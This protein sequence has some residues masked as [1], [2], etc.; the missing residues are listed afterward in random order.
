MD[1]LDKILA[2]QNLG[3]RKEVGAMIRKGRVC[4]NGERVCRPDHKLDPEK[5]TVSVDGNPLRFARQV[6]Y[7]MHKP[8]GVLSA[9]RDP[10]APT[11]LD[12][13]RPDQ[14]RR[15]L[16]PAGR[17]DK[18]TEGLLILTDDGAFAHRM[19]SPRS[20]VFKRYIAVLDRPADPEDVR[21]FAEGL[22]LEAGLRGLPA[23]LC[24]LEGSAAQVE[25]CEGKFHLVKRMFAAR[26]K[27]VVHLKRVQI[28][29]LVL[30][31]ALL[32]GQAREL[33]AEEC[34]SVFLP[35]PEDRLKIQK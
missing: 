6:Y 17:L 10:H 13:L 23:R 1:R 22:V 29:G 31:G 30:D 18:D 26:G 15:G 28:G 33:S 32:P 5:D 25:L 14:K 24:L 16:F 27:T 20:R 11:V 7:M 35:L 34:A 3:S 21:A 12:L 9:S 4:V 8:A 19:L 2:S